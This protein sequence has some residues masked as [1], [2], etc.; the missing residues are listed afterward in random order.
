MEGLNR[1]FDTH[2]YSYA[3]LISGILRHGMPLPSVI[4]LITSLTFDHDLIN[5]WKAGVIRMLKRYIKDGTAAKNE[6]PECH[7]S[8][9]VYQGGCVTC[10]QC[11]YSGCS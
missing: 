3:K 9:L 4:N 7:T 11:N 10:T 5:T 6:C 1:V 2:Y 8:S